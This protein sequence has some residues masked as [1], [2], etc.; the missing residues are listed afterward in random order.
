MTPMEVRIGVL[1]GILILNA[2]IVWRW[3]HKQP[4]SEENWMVPGAWTA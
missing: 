4:R 3:E 1:C 2:I